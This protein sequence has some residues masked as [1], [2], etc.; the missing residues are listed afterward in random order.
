MSEHTPGPWI[1]ASHQSHIVGIPIVGPDGRS[2]GF[3]ATLASVT[4]E[5]R[6][7]NEHSLTCECRA[8]GSRP[9]DAR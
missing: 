9:D 7:F 5:G 8:D 6:E 4:P 1:A 3:A 2:I